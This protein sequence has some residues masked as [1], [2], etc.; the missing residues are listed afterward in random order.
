MGRHWTVGIL[1]E[2]VAAVKHKLHFDQINYLAQ[3]G[4]KFRGPRKRDAVK[5]PDSEF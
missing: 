1:R 4:V 2:F 3:G 5:W